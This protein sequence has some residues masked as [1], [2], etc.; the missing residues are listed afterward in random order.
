[1]LYAFSRSYER[2]K[3]Q[4]RTRDNSIDLY[5]QWNVFDKEKKTHV[6]LTFIGDVSSRLNMKSFLE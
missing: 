1:V 4:D 6:V 3:L 2:F 5:S